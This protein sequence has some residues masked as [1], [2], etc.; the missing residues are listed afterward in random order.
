MVAGTS[1]LYFDSSNVLGTTMMIV[2]AGATMMIVAVGTTMGAAVGV[3]TTTIP[4]GT[5]CSLLENH[6]S[7][8][9]STGDPET[10]LENEGAITWPY[11]ILY[12][13]PLQNNLYNPTRNQTL[14]N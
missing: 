4:T 6:E 3:A 7:H 11:T 9:H 2:A 5:V 13:T 1:T 10:L 14:L 8:S 12:D